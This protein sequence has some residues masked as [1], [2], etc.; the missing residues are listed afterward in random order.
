[1]PNACL[2]FVPDIIKAIF[3]L[4]QIFQKSSKIIRSLGQG[5]S[6]AS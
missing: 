1:M 3:M 2:Q 4:L 6:K 5:I